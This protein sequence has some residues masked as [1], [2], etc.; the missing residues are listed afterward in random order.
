M[1][2][3]RWILCWTAVVALPA[4]AQSGRRPAP[5]RDAMVVSSHVLGSE[6]GAEVLRR[7][8]NAVD[9]AVAVF[10][11][12]AVTHP[13]AGNLGGGGFMLIR[14]ADGETVALDF[15]EMAPATSPAR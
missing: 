12:L 5:A 11:T 10:L 7:G 3:L 8:G 14:M 6:A 4:H 9:A 15:R 2:T 1:R 13:Q